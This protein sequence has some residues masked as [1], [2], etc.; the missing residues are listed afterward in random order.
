MPKCGTHLL[1]RLISGLTGCERSKES[2]RTLSVAEAQSVLDSHEKLSGRFLRGHQVHTPEIEQLLAER[3]VR[4]VFII[5]DPRDTVV[6]HAHWVTSDQHGSEANRTFYKSL[7][8]IDQR[9]MTSICGRPAGWNEGK[10]LVEESENLQYHGVREHVG[11]RL[12]R[13][14]P[15]FRSA[16]VCTVRFEDLVGPQGGGAADV[17]EDEILRVADFLEIEVARNAVCDIVESLFDPTA[18]TFRRGQAGGWK[19]EFNDLHKLVFK[20]V[21]GKELIELGYE[22]EFD[23]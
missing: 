11:Q 3:S 23:W 18:K 6:S 7:P 8:S 1:G 15:W 12:Q 20:A 21:A 19:E 14:L 22:T 9:I 4:V 13:Y 5:R 2:L 17:Q 10:P 16:A